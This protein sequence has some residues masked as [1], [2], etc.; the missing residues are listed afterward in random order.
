MTNKPFSFLIVGFVFGLATAI[1]V[2][3]YGAPEVLFQE[4]DSRYGF[5]D[6]VALLEKAASDNGWVIPKQYRLDMS[7]KKAGHDIL[8]VSVIE[9]CRPEHAA[10]ILGQDKFMHFSTMMPCRVAVYQ[11]SDGT[12]SIA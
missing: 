12:V 5:E 3:R 10:K 2:L 11:K 6:S 8:P 7:L 4:N 9:L 1:V